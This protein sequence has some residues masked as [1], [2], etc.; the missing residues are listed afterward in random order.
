MRFNILVTLVDHNGHSPTSG[1]VNL[2]RKADG[3]VVTGKKVYSSETEAS[4]KA[5]P[6]AGW[7][8]IRRVSVADYMAQIGAI[9]AAARKAAVIAADAWLNPAPIV[10][11]VPA[12]AAKKVVKKAKRKVVAKKKVSRKA[13]K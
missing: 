8:F 5:R 6:A 2:Y 12:V 13:R 11:A 4:R 1:V 9:E 7:T 10:P 3:S